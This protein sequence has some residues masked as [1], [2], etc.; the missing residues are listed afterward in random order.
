MFDPIYIDKT[1]PAETNLQ[2]REL[3]DPVL[4]L[5]LPETRSPE[6]DVPDFEEPSTSGPALADLFLERAKY[7]Q[8]M[9]APL[10]VTVPATPAPAPVTP[11]AKPVS[12]KVAPLTP[13]ATR[14]APPPKVD[15]SPKTIP[16]SVAP[17][18][19]AEPRSEPV[20]EPITVA[21][22][23]A[24]SALE[25]P[26]HQ[27]VSPDPLGIP[28]TRGYGNASV[29]ASPAK[30]PSMGSIALAST[31]RRVPPLESFQGMDVIRSGRMAVQSLD[32]PD[33][34][35]VKREVKMSHST[36]D[37]YGTLYAGEKQLDEY[38]AYTHL[39]AEIL[40]ALTDNQRR[41]RDF[42]HGQLHLMRMMGADLAEDNRRLSSLEGAFEIGR[43]SLGDVNI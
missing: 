23:P 9:Q 1:L 30:M 13:P 32:L 14:T 11:P 36:D 16:I 25:T 38:S 43:E 6:R 3:G 31:T 34:R 24:P 7:L 4:E 40:Q 42:R 12:P 19:K 35:E 26:S 29:E 37:P 27:E 21:S 18:P 28:S 20:T 17:E 33:T 2:K 5:P 22:S 10:N 39:N 15:A 41:E 8:A